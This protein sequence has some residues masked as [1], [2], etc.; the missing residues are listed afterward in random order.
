M[1]VGI[2]LDNARCLLEWGQNVLFLLTAHRE[3]SSVH[4]SYYSFL[5]A[6]VCDR[7]NDKNLTDADGVFD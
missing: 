7:Y 1:S 2:G 4:L 6:Y 3:D 5:C